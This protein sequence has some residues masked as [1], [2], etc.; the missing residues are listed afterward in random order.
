MSGQFGFWDFE[1]R[2]R[3]LSVEGDPGLARK[4]WRAIGLLCCQLERQAL[5]LDWAFE[6]QG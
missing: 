4:K 3:E 2:L 5:E 1:D 6:A